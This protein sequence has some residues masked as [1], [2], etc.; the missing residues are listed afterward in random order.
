MKRLSSKDQFKSIFPFFV[1]AII[2]IIFG[3]LTRGKVF[4]G[5]NLTLIL[6]QSIVLIIASLGVT[7]VMS[8]GALDFS[9]GSIMAVS[10][11]AGV[12]AAKTSLLLAVIVM[13]A[14]CTGLGFLNGVLVSRLKMS[15]FIVTICMMFIFRGLNIFLMVNTGAVPS[16]LY[17]SRLLN[18]YPFKI[19]VMVVVLIALVILFEFTRFGS[20]CRAIGAGELC[21]IYSGVNVPRIKILAFTLAGCTAGIAAIILMVRTGVAAP[22][23]AELMETNI[24][25]VLVLGGLPITGGYGS[26][27]WSG[28]VGALTLTVLTNGLIILGT[29]AA[30]LQLAQGIIF[31]I[32]VVVSR[33]TRANI[34]VK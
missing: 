17:V 1:L 22:Q 21:A 28:L 34:I 15:S 23:T 32:A 9:Q 18:N 24:L 2:L 19:T 4:Q 5:R 33:E 31:L 29:S 13:I 7:F 8:M 20:Y 10:T 30:V 12:Y 25:T 11:L 27:I 6:E 14:I 16:P 3:V 26:R